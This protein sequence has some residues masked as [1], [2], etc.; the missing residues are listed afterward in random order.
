MEEGILKSVEKNKRQPYYDTH[1]VHATDITLGLQFTYYS[2]NYTAVIRTLRIHYS[3]RCL[4]I[5]DR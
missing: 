1:Q 2:N 3:A 5:R 4:E